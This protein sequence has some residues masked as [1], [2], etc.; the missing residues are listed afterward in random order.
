MRLLLTFLLLFSLADAMSNSQGSSPQT[1][2]APG[3]PSQSAKKPDQ[4]ARPDLPGKVDEQG[5]GVGRV[6][7]HFL[8]LVELIVH[9][10]EASL[11][12][13]RLSRLGGNQSVFVRRGV[14][15][16]FSTSSTRIRKRGAKRKT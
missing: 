7:P 13:R 3:A 2:P 16:I 4:A 1:A 12:T 15:R 6:A 9:F 8:I 14:Q 11:Q 5:H 10:P